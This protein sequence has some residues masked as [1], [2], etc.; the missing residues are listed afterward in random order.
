LAISQSLAPGEKEGG[1]SGGIGAHVLML[2]RMIKEAGDFRQC[3]SVATNIPEIVVALDA[4]IAR[5]QQART[6]IDE[7][8]SSPSASTPVVTH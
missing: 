7:S 3:D 6:L 5:L 2:W 4:E 1:L 8:T